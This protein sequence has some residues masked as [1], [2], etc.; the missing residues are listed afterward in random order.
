MRTAPIIVGLLSGT[1][2]F[3]IAGRISSEMPQRVDVGDGSVLRM[4]IEGKRGPVVVLEMETD[5]RLRARLAEFTRVV[6]YQRAGW[7]D[8]VVGGSKR[9]AGQIAQELHAALGKS[10][11]NPPYIL[12][13][14]TVGSL[15]V[16]RFAQ[17][18]PR[19]VAGLILIDPLVE[20]EAP[21]ATLDWLKANHPETFNQ[22]HKTIEEIAS[23]AG[24][25][26]E[27][28]RYLHAVE[29]KKYEQ[30]LFQAAAEQR[31]GWRE[32]V[33]NR[34]QSEES[35]REIYSYITSYRGAERDEFLAFEETFQQ[36]RS[37]GPLPAVPI[38]VITGMRVDGGANSD[39]ASFG[40]AEREYIRQ[41]Q[42]RLMINQTTAQGVTSDK[43]QFDLAQSDPDLL[44]NVVNAMVEKAAAERP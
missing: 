26:L 37:G 21:R 13:G 3:L 40:R 23:Q 1:A 44:V 31:K 27:W 19:D 9:D 29:R 7:G 18:F 22:F 15:F 20:E 11:L 24:P 4:H 16:R 6:D 2:A 17:M 14:D 43:A 36:L 12:V 42:A 38:R 10:N 32:I 35:A 41:Q 5:E 8:S 28:V 34:L 33:N 30:I 39:Q 25:T